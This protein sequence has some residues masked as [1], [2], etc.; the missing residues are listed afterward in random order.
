MLVCFPVFLSQQFIFAHT[1][2]LELTQIHPHKYLRKST[3]ALGRY[4]K[5]HLHPSTEGLRGHGV[6]VCP[7]RAGI[8]PSIPETGSGT[9]LT[10]WLGS[11]WHSFCLELRIGQTVSPSAVK[12]VC[13]GKLC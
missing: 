9:A 10:S 13:I 11:A 5:E 1:Q 4:L 2:E 3:S 8:R 7:P 6:C 12:Y